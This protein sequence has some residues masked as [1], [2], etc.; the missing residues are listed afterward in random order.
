MPNTPTKSGVPWL[1]GE[2][3]VINKKD[4][5]RSLET[6]ETVK[7]TYTVDGRV[8]DQGEGTVV[9]VFAGRDSS[10]LVVNSCLFLNVLSFSHLRFSRA[11]EGA[12]RIELIDES[13][14]LILVPVVDK[15][16]RNRVRELVG[17]PCQFDE[18]CGH[19]VDEEEEED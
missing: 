14:R 4:M 2:G 15:Q 9:K 6:L 18:A 7:Y 10:T 3:T 5:L 17:P 13:R 8:V 16:P 12:S 11:K 19:L 1:I